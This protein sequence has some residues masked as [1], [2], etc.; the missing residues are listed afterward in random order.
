MEEEQ[1]VD[2]RVKKENTHN[3]LMST[4]LYINAIDLKKPT[5]SK[6]L[7]ERRRS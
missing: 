4:V 3:F 2:V 6:R 5:E 7:V 1:S